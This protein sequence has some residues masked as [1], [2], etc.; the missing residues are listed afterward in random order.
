MQMYS[1]VPHF[2]K[3]S[4][5]TSTITMGALVKMRLNTVK[6]MMSFWTRPGSLNVALKLSRPKKKEYSNL[7]TL[8]DKT[9]LSKEMNPK[10]CLW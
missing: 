6:K 2:R 7:L 3:T 4:P 1:W 5:T 8:Y 9:T 10:V